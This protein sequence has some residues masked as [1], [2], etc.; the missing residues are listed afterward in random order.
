MSY[1]GDTSAKKL[2]RAAL[3]LRTFE[4]AT[5]DPRQA[6][7]LVLSGP[8][9]GDASAVQA[10][11][12]QPENIWAVD[13]DGSAIEKARLLHPDV[14]FAE[15]DALDFCK[16]HR[17]EF[18]IIFL[19][20]CSPLSRPKVQYLVQC[21][22]WACKHNAF[23]GAGFMYGR[24]G[25]HLRK[26]LD[27]I[28]D[29]FRSNLARTQTAS[30]AELE[31]WL[32]YVRE[33]LPPQYR[34]CE[35]TPDGHRT[36]MRDESMSG[37]VLAKNMNGFARWQ[38][39][40]RFIREVGLDSGVI[41]FSAAMQLY[42]SSR[43]VGRKLKPGTPMLYYM[44]RFVRPFRRVSRRVLEQHWWRSVDAFETRFGLE[45]SASI[46]DPDNVALRKAAVR[47]ARLL[48]PEKRRH[49]AGLYGVSREQLAAWLAVDT[50]HTAKQIANQEPRDLSL[51]FMTELLN[52][53]LT[54]ARAAQVIDAWRKK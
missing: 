13:V 32:E 27:E 21:A 34:H 29:Q 14:R 22:T 3:W 16:K 39:A 44:G 33:T 15:S 6:R 11:G 25:P 42:R 35:L 51:E 30:D 38:A 7:V 26:I 54:P 49:I 17:H 4:R 53:D 19:D 37:G 52:T 20:F 10:F 28:R 50:R 23:V 40:R 48:A 47:A 1:E 45:V 8:S 12:V 31:S 46:Q 18:D 9:A 43:R 24:E 2:A 36:H 5:F 41:I